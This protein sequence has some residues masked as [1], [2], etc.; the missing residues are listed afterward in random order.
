[1]GGRREREPH[2]EGPEHLAPPARERRRVF[3][4]SKRGQLGGPTPWI[5]GVQRQVPEQAVAAVGTAGA[6]S[7][8]GRGAVMFPWGWTR[9]LNADLG[10]PER[11]L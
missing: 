5:G 4:P 9:T 11:S 7:M 10:T 1:M 2:L 6:L 8:V 3:H